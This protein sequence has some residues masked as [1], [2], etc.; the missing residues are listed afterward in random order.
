MSKALG[1]CI[2]GSVEKDCS[3]FSIAQ[4]AKLLGKLGRASVESLKTIF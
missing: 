3:H 1:L 2:G 4:E